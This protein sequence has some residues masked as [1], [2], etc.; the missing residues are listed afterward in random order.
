MEVFRAVDESVKGRRSQQP[1]TPDWWDSL[2]PKEKEVVELVRQGLTNQQ[3]ADNI[4]VA[5]NTVKEHLKHIKEKTGFGKIR[6]AVQA[7]ARREISAPQ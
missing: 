5:L 1:D 4:S 6:L 7:Q 2:S 3:I